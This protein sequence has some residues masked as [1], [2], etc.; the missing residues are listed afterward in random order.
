MQGARTRP[1]DRPYSETSRNNGPKIVAGIIVLAALAGVGWW[2]FARTRPESGVVSR[3]TIVPTVSLAGDVT[4][5]PDKIAYVMPP[6]TAP[7]KAVHA[8]LGENVKKG[9]LIAELT[10]PA[11]DQQ[12]R[13]AESALKTAEASY[14]SALTSAG[15][16]VRSAKANV[17]AARAREKAA[18]AA[19]KAAAAPAEITITPEGTETTTPA[20]ATTTAPASADMVAAQ[21]DRISAEADLAEAISQRNVSVA[22]FRQAVESARANYLRAKSGARLDDVRSPIEGT[23]TQLN[24]TT[25]Q[26]VGEDGKTPIAVIVNLDALELQANVAPEAVEE[27]KVDREGTLLVTEVPGEEFKARVRSVVTVPTKDGKTAYRAILRVL[28]KGGAVKP[29]MKGAVAIR[30]EERRDVLAVPVGAVRYDKEGRSVVSVLQGE[31]WMDR[32][33]EVG[34]SDGTYQEI[35]S[36][37]KEGETVKVYKK[38]MR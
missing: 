3:R 19:M 26:N 6:F 12:I 31:Q 13:D 20:P 17:D 34:L 10:A 9:E 38:L 30:L 4:V 7:V 35:R 16:D 5:P 11:L 8:T 15:G 25:G 29:G 1:M 28:N 37:V 22:P 32:V 14:Q 36:G 33:V 2:A 24:A 27:V 23:V 21:R 18:R